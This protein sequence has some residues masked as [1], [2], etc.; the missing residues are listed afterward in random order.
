[1]D[2][3]CDIDGTIAD[4]EHR[5]HF[6]T[7]KPKNWP[8]FNKAMVNDGVVTPVLTVVQS[9][10]SSGNRV[11]FMSGRDSSCREMTTNWLADKCGIRVAPHSDLSW[12][13]MLN[14]IF[15]LY[16]RAE[17]DYRRDDII[18]T[19]L[20]EKVRADGYDPQFVIDDR[21]QVVRR[22]KSQGMFVFDVYQGEGEF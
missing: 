10:I 21:P 1:M 18:K 2:F 19:E 4:I 14:N 6:V 9:L 20:L 17:K 3:I 13:D 22:W 11:V 16:M 15:P 8:A 7:T 5:R 12:S